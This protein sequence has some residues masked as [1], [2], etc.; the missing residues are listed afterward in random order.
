MTMVACYM[1]CSVTENSN[2]P[3]YRV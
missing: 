2:V 1:H 3:M